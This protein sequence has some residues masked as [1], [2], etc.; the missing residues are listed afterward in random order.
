M[1]RDGKYYQGR[2]HPQNPQKYKGDV[3][4]IIY[5]S[6]W[7]LKFMKW[8]DTNKNIL[9]YSSEEFFIPYFDPTTKKVRRYFPDFYIKYISSNGEIKK[10]IV[11]IKP[12]RET[13]EPVATKNKRKKTLLNET[14]T[15]A[16]NQAKWEAAREFCK[17]RL[18]EFKVIT[19]NE[20]GI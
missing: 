20:L 18:M 3:K 9:E 14:L 8:C 12:L 19:E 16:K 10:A 4:N 2:F 5:R 1:P 13:K 7:E 11:E 17:D 15:Y 6:G